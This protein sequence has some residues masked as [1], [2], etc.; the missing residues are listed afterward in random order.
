M[1]TTEVREHN[2]YTT[3]DFVADVVFVIVLIGA[4]CGLLE[5]VGSF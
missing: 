2:R 3:Q 1:K 4:A 5:L